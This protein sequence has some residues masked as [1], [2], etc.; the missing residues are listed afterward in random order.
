MPLP[1]RPL[2]P[3]GNRLPV[4]VTDRKLVAELMD[5]Q[6]GGCAACAASLPARLEIL[7]PA[8]RVCMLYKLLPRALVP[9]LVLQVRNLLGLLLCEVLTG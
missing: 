4:T 9:G 8:Q 5:L 2:F 6:R 3:A 1:R 7:R